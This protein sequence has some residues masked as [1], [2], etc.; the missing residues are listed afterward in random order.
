MVFFHN[1][2]FVKMNSRDAASLA[3]DAA[4]IFWQQARIPTQF[5]ARCIDKLIKLYKT[6]LSIQKKTPDKRTGQSKPTEQRF[7]DELDDLFDI[8]SDDAL[9]VIRIEEDKLFLINQRKKGRPG[10]MIGADMVLYAQEKRSILRK[11]RAEAMKR[12]N[13]EEMA[14]QFGKLDTVSSVHFIFCALQLT[15]HF[16][17]CNRT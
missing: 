15:F 7:S 14:S 2:R 11:E 10:S 6:W 16:S 8:A 12:K 13:D 17:Q 5:R 1:M 9:K 4:L 3:I